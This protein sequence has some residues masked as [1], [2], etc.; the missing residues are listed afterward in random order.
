LVIGK[1]SLQ[2]VTDI[3]AIIPVVTGLIGLI[4][5]PLF[6][7]WQDRLAREDNAAHPD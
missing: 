1:R 5:A 6:I 3:L 4:G 7:L 2:I